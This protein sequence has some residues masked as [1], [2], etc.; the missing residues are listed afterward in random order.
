MKTSKKKESAEEVKKEKNKKPASAKSDKTENLV[1]II[2]FILLIVVGAGIATKGFGL[3]Q[4]GIDDN[5]R[6]RVHI[7]NDPST[8]NKNASVLIIAF[9]DYECPFCKK[10]EQT[11]KNILEKY[12][13]E[14]VYIFKD[15][16]LTRTHPNAYNSALA[17]ECAKEQAKFWEYHNLLFEHSDQLEIQYLKE[18]AKLLE[19]DTEKFNNCLETQQYKHEVEKDIQT[20]N[21]VGVTGT[22]IFFI[23]GIK[24]IGAQPEHEFIKII[25][26]ELKA[27]K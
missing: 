6:I 27:R 16:P 7:G 15:Y 17:A 19:L 12:P 8:G 18:Y 23:N 13:D 10:A 14:I 20:A 4:G 3:F 5:V 22:P 11:I 25:N 9:S 21:S 1:A 26:N 2:I 24:V